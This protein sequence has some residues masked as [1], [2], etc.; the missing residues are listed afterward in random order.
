MTDTVAR[1]RP[2]IRVLAVAAAVLVLIV[3]VGGWFLLRPAPE[4]IDLV[5]AQPATVT[6]LTAPAGV[7]AKCVEPTA[8]K[9][10]EYADFAFAGTVVAIEGGTVTLEATR[11]YLGEPVDEVRVAQEGDTSETMMGSGKFEIGKN[12]LVASN[13]GGVLVCGYSGEADAPGLREL[14]DEAF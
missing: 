3:A 8:A 13:D 4:P 10:K 14:Y 5:T 9:L 1:P 7:A 6:D 12:Y 11:V 2:G